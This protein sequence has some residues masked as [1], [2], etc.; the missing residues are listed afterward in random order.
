MVSRGRD[1]FSLD[2]SLNC[3]TFSPDGNFLT[4][5]GREVSCFRRSS[6]TNCS[7][8]SPKWNFFINREL[9]SHKLQILALAKPMGWHHIWIVRFAFG[10]LIVARS[11]PS[12]RWRKHFVLQMLFLVFY[13]FWCWLMDMAVGESENDFVF[14][15]DQMNAGMVTWS[16]DGQQLAVLTRY[17]PFSFISW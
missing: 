6:Y 12:V 11:L 3:I 9:W 16:P 5:R 10:R 14:Q 17:L 2:S 8:F 1:N 13:E 15:M 7:V 4:S